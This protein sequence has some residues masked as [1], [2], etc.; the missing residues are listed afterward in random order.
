[1]KSAIRRFFIGYLWAGG[2][3]VKNKF[4]DENFSQTQ[5]VVFA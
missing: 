5:L 3:S 4:A 2:E 1:M